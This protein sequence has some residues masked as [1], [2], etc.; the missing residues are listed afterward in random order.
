MGTDIEQASNPLLKSNINRSKLLIEQ[1]LQK[2]KIKV[3]KLEEYHAKIGQEG[4]DNRKF[5]REISDE[6]KNAGQLCQECSQDI[7]NYS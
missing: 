5:R 6:L 3:K 4:T 1:Q 7:K 2:I